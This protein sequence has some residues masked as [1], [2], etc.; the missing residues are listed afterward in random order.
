MDRITPK[1]RTEATVPLPGEVEEAKQNA[2]G[3][4]YRI[5]GHCGAKDQVPPEAIIGAWKVDAQG[6]I[7]GGF[8]EN[9]NYDTKR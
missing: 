3:W 4:V 2:N 8:L 9:E 7:V 5:A 1:M 6:K